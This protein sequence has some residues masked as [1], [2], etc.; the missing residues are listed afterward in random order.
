MDLQRAVARTETVDSREG[1]NSNWCPPAA[2]DVQTLIVLG[3]FTVALLSNRTTVGLSRPSTKCRIL[4]NRV[5]GRIK[6]T[7]VRLRFRHNA[8]ESP[9]FAPPIFVVMAG[10]V[11]AIHVVPSALLSRGWPGQAR[12]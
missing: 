4:L 7:A 11:P 10:L 2:G 3:V 5:D 12:P 6:S 1:G 8:E 9:P